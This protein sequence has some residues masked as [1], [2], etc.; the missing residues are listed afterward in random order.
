MANC[1]LLLL[2]TC[3]TL[4][5]TAGSTS[6]GHAI[7]RA[8]PD[9]PVP[10]ILQSQLTMNATRDQTPGRIYTLEEISP[11][12]ESGTEPFCDP[13]PSS[14]WFRFTFAYY[15]RFPGERCIFA[16]CLD[17]CNRNR[18]DLVFPRNPAELRAQ[19][20]FATES[21]GDVFFGVYLPFDYDTNVTCSGH[22]CNKVLKYTNGS[23]FIYHDWM[24][25]MFDRTAGQDHC[26][27]AP[28][29][30]P[31][32]QQQVVPATCVWSAGFACMALCPTPGPALR[33]GDLHGI[34][35]SLP[36][37][38]NNVPAILR[39]PRNKIPVTSSSEKDFMTAPV[40]PLE[41][42]PLPPPTVTTSNDPTAVLAYDCSSPRDIKPMRADSSGRTCTANHEPVNQR[43]ASYLLLQ[44]SEGVDITVR[45]CQV[46][47]TIIPFYCGVWSHNVFTPTWLKIEEDIRVTA[48]DC[49]V[50]WHTGQF[51]DSQ[52]NVHQLRL[53]ST[54]RIYY[55]S[56]GHTQAKDGKVTC[57]G[58]DFWYKGKKYPDMVVVVSREFTLTTQPA[59][60]ID[61]N[62]VH[63]VRYDLILPCPA[64]ELYCQSSTM[65]AFVWAPP[66]TLCPY[67]VLRNVTGI[68][69]TDDNGVDTFISTDQSM[70]R[71]LIVDVVTRCDRVVLKTNYRQLFLTADIHSDAFP[72]GLPL[73]EMSI[74]TYSNQQDGYLF[75]YLTKYIRR[76]LRAVHFNVCQ[77]RE[78]E[79]RGNY[80]ALLAEQHGSID[81]DTASLGNGFFVTQAGEA[82]YRFRCKRLTVTVRATEECYSALPVTLTTAD[83]D[84]YLRQRGQPNASVEL[85][86]EA[87]SRR[88]TDRGIAVPCNEHFPASYAGL[89]KSWIQLRPALHFVPPPPVMDALALHQ[90]HL[91]D[92]G[93]LDFEAGGIYV[94]QAV[95]AMEKHMQTKRAMQDVSFRLAKSAQQLG[96]SSSSPSSAV[97]FTPDALLTALP[98]ISWWTPV[99]EFLK[100]WGAFT[101]I[102]VG[103]YHILVIILRCYGFCLPSLF[104]LF[105]TWAWP[106]LQRFVQRHTRRPPPPA[107]PHDDAP[108][109]YDQVSSTHTPA[110]EPP[111]SPPPTSTGTRRRTPTGADTVEPIRQA[112]EESKQQG[113]PTD[114]A[115]PP[116]APAPA[117][118]GQPDKMA[119][120]LATLS[121]EER[122]IYT[123]SIKGMAQVTET[124]S[125]PETDTKPDLSSPPPS[126]GRSQTPLNNVRVIKKPGL[127]GKP[128]TSPRPWIK[129]TWSKVLPD[130]PMENLHP[131]ARTA[132]IHQP[133]AAYN[134]A[135]NTLYMLPGSTIE[136]RT[137]TPRAQL[138]E[139][140]P[141]GFSANLTESRR[142]TPAK[143]PR[144]SPDSIINEEI[145]PRMN[146]WSRGPTGSP[147]GFKT[148]RPH[149]SYNDRPSPVQNRKDL[150]ERLTELK[151]E[152]QTSPVL[153]QTEN[154][155]P[156]LDQLLAEIS[157]LTSGLEESEHTR[158]HFTNAINTY[159]HLSKRARR[160]YDEHRPSAELAD[161]EVPAQA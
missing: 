75:G 76:E 18:A 161:G 127:P 115:S 132:P 90:L 47:E 9:L 95:Q 131:F 109:G 93:D 141:A 10:A 44:K 77:Q 118:L 87:H 8:S 49:H 143:S 4:W 3:A 24:G 65:G 139:S 158:G 15:A 42:P 128:R 72:A 61:N 152:I 60:I 64:H 25:A 138:T 45:Q 36:R 12:P 50:L 82:W 52:G 151:R 70:I 6:P 144:Q 159:R 149:A 88:L 54:T 98:S 140:P 28:K 19:L 80:D 130:I 100:T 57:Q 67:F 94:A 121:P 62:L 86:V 78:Q 150:A 160:L 2:T 116:S 156:G 46:T 129:D 117:D 124:N 11:I 135:N 134:V 102:W 125:K 96:W 142:A 34:P 63:V 21:V 39:K 14:D 30:G 133:T 16:Q 66:P 112:N 114:A 104:D 38:F 108:P 51:L 103:L 43:N 81:G 145:P 122:D 84:S 157:T 56:I 153:G 154:K 31:Y 27:V 26:Y 137:N 73:D 107:A 41:T 155:I 29:G 71:L 123:K 113:T 126:T 22:G 85:F 74:L 111:P 101:S 17:T 147:L 59:R 48:Q 20:S 1:H 105:G 53:N 33:P 119:M 146:R 110:L 89:G 5:G 148:F 92:P 69:V 68:V 13:E 7:G 23:S 32:H 37:L 35:V 120:F 97:A 79:R 99:W 91:E 40:T 83:L 58:G 55:H 136:D 106:P